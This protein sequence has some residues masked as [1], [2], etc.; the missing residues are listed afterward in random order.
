MS[1]TDRIQYTS[2]YIASCCDF[3]FQEKVFIFIFQATMFGKA[4]FT[5]RKTDT[6]IVW[7]IVAFH[8]AFI[9]NA[10]RIICCQIATPVVYVI[11]SVEKKKINKVYAT[12]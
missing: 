1:S 7:I 5:L 8:E 10:L 11:Y 4:R 6:L 3:S 12:L 2:Y 9:S